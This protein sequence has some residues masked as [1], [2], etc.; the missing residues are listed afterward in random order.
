MLL[1][2]DF[3]R[4]THGGVS[5]SNVKHILPNLILNDPYGVGESLSANL[6][7]YSLDTGQKRVEMLL[8]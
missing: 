2:F 7:N 8:S 1:Q 6:L 4:Q 5:K 3:E